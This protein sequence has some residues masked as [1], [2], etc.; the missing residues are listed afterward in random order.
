MKK[1]FN[2]F[3]YKIFIFLFLGIFLLYSVYG[4]ETPKIDL[5]NVSI[6]INGKQTTDPIATPLKAIGL[7][8]VLSL[9]PYILIMMTPYIRIV[10]VFSMLRSALGTQQNPT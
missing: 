6:E 5:P 4:A 1:L 2:Y 10:I 9:A 7:I 3:N 8:T